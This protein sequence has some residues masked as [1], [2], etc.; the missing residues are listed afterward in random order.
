M[1]LKV[2]LCC[3]HERIPFATTS[4]QTI[5]AVKIDNQLDAMIVIY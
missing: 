3:E 2:I 1:K 4:S 5:Y